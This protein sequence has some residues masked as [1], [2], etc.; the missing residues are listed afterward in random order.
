MKFSRLQDRLQFANL[1]PA[2][3]IALSFFSVIFVGTIL[4]S[5]P[6]SNH[7]NQAATVLD[8]LFTAT[9]A[10][11]VTGLTT[12]VVVE[13]Y[14]L[15]GQVIILGL[16]QIGGLGLMTLIAAF[17]IFLSGKL[18][19]TDKMALS[20]AVNRTDFKDFLKFIR[21][22]IKYTIVFEGFG[23]LLLSFVFVPQFGWGEGLFKSLFIAV[24][25]FCN[26]GL[27][28]L[29]SVSLQ[30]YVNNPLVNFTVAALIVMGGL[31][32]GVWFELS[33]ASKRIFKPNQGWHRIIREVKVHARIV[34]ITTFILII[35]G[36]ALILMLE[37]GNPN[38]LQ[39]LP[40]FSQLMAASFQSITL[41]TAG[42]S[43]LIIG[44]FRPATLLVMMVFMF[45]G[46]SP[47]GTAGGIK[48][49][50][51]AILI[52]MIVA[53]L[54]SQKNIV[55]FGR[56]IEREVFRKAFIVAFIL[57]MTLLVGIV[58][59]LAVEPF[60]FMDLA[61]EAT[62]AIATVGLSTGITSSLSSAGKLII[63][64]LMYLG[65]IG[66]LTLMLSVG[67]HP[68]MSK[69]NDLTYPSANIL[70]G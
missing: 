20:E 47:G 17:L 2:Q 28:I 10:V 32:F 58:A 35:S 56:T 22:I 63:I 39:P 60:S 24:S 31:G 12:I 61:F 16:M 53:E 21:N 34:L 6:I 14:T 7:P 46:G 40:P 48:T 62:S 18:T 66:P 5:L 42:F 8:H 50:T 33:R 68:K 30:A 15:F 43:T 23:V 69:A 49:T 37:A 29:G 44:M 45:I 27:D 3:Q 59:L 41:R 11:C 9:S 26:A 19:L 52:L 1:S 36:T 57:L 65:R 54:R 55:V 13:Q 64:A 38:S 67:R 4:L 51:V 70:I 25:A